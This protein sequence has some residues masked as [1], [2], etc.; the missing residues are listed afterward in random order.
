MSFHSTPPDESSVSLP[1]SFG[2]IYLN[3]STRPGSEKKACP[4]QR[5]QAYL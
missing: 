2:V 4:L 3:I 5:E 1:V